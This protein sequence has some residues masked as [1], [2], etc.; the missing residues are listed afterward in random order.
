MGGT[1][2]KWGGPG[3]TGPPAGDGPESKEGCLKCVRLD[4]GRAFKPVNL[5]V[6]AS[7]VVALCIAKAK[8]S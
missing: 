6:E 2:F 4:A 5:S 3:T 7:Y 8:K 1:D